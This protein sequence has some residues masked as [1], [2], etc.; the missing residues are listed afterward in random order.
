[1]GL[2]LK[3]GFGLIGT[4]GAVVFIFGF[5]V[6]SP[7]Q[8]N[9]YA[10]TLENNSSLFLTEG[11]GLVIKVGK[12]TYFVESK[13]SYPF[14]EREEWNEFIV[15]KTSSGKGEWKYRIRNEKKRFQILSSGKYYKLLRDISFQK[16]HILI[17]DTFTNLTNEPIGIVFENEVTSFYSPE[18]IFV[19][20]Y[21]RGIIQTQSPNPTIFISG[22]NSG[23]GMVPVLHPINQAVNLR[24][25]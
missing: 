9:F 24:L 16:D 21:S 8:T 15:S 14:M 10:S 25:F 19:A 2:N 3:K 4:L 18:E 11:G 12:E 20:G 13:F 17:K 22:K 1:M 6:V 5:S 7:A 23:L